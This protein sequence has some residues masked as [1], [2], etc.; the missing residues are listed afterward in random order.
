[1]NQNDDSSYSSEDHVEWDLMNTCSYSVTTEK[2]DKQQLNGLL[3]HTQTKQI[4]L[5]L[6]THNHGK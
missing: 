2:K 3:K 5:S 6:T 4:S 1:M